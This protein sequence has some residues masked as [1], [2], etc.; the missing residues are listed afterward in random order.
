LAL[1]EGERGEPLS[2]DERARVPSSLG[3][4][5]ARRGRKSPAGENLDAAARL[6]AAR[7][8]LG[9]GEKY[10]NTE[11][12]AG[13]WGGLESELVTGGRQGE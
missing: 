8:I 11:G 13:E 1:D 4:A 10:R 3:A 12:A 5:P 6:S 2:Q 7:L 9:G